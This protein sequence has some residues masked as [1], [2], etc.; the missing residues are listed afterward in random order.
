MGNL[1]LNF[2]DFCKGRRSQPA[3]VTQNARQPTIFGILEI[4]RWV[5]AALQWLAVVHSLICLMATTSS[6]SLFLARYTTPK[7][8]WPS[9][10][11][12]SYRSEGSERRVRLEDDEDDEDRDGP[13][14]GG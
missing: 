6:D 14:D 2:G 1:E 9:L 5:S 4:C 12:N 10:S 7:L 8:P 13:A 3:I 11:S